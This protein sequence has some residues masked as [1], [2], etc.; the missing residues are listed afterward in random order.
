MIH[1]N[2]QLNPTNRRGSIL[3]MVLIL[4]PVLV[5][6]VGFAIDYAYMQRARTELSEGDGLGS[7]ISRQCLIRNGRRQSCPGDSNQ[8][9][10]PKPGVRRAPDIGCEQHRVWPISTTNRRHME[11]CPE[12]IAE[13]C[14]QN[15][16][17]SRNEFTR[18]QYSHIFWN[19]IWSPHVP[20]LLQCRCRLRQLGHCAGTRSQQQHETCHHG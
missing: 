6:F 14:G 19:D 4:L 17:I 1:D 5:L 10:V 15:Q 11:F 7:Q 16:W 18:W 8:Y 13:K 12:R 2:N 3:T 9:R 20:A